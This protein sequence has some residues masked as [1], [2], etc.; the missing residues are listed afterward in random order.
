MIVIRYRSY[1]SILRRTVQ[2]FMICSLCLSEP[3]AI[4]LA[5]HSRFQPSFSRLWFGLAS[6][7]CR[8]PPRGHHLIMF[9]SRMKIAIFLHHR[10]FLSHSCLTEVDPDSKNQLRI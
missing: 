1:V 10:A 6:R 3:H 4:S 7:A 2:S 9:P 8:A 5:S